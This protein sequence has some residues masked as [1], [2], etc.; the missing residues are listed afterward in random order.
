MVDNLAIGLFPVLVT[1]LG[2]YVNFLQANP[3]M[4]GVVAGIYWAL[5]PLLR[6]IT[7]PRFAS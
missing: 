7:V 2:S 4:F 3:A 6:K 1:L 5:K